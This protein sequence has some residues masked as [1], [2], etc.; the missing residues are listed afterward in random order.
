M[1]FYVKGASGEPEEPDPQPTV[2]YKLATELKT[3]DE[4]VIY[5]PGAKKALSSE[6]LGNYYLAAK[7]ATVEENA[8]AEPDAST[9]WTVTVNED[10]S[11]SFKQ[12]S[13]DLSTYVNGTHINISNTA[14]GH[15]PN[16]ILEPVTG[17]DS[18]TMKSATVAKED[19]T[20]VYAEY[21]SRYDE[22]TVYAT[23]TPTGDAYAMQFYVK[24]QAPK[25][26]ALAETVKDGDNAVIVLASKNK[27][28]STTGYLYEKKNQR[29]MLPADV[30]VEDGTITSDT[31]GLVYTVHV[32][33]DGGVLLEADGKY[34]TAG[35]TGSELFLS[36]T[37]TTY[38]TWELVQAEGGWF[39]KSVNAKYNNND[40]F[41]EFY[42][43]FTTYGKNSNA[44]LTIY[45]FAFYIE[46]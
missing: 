3:G 44:D 14:E 40:Q 34:L 43:N 27:A 25:G 31:E 1:Q 35:D 13:Y 46:G 12:G 9:V 22:F 21:Y 45:T 24:E 17:T 29:Q 8:I 19:G 41:V 10:G 33:E 15:D 30:T 39:I 28:I 2:S 5:N 20:P 7:N 37:Q 11:Y 16:W 36:D 4:V 18:F 26:F 42:T 23:S 6:P 38:S 32:L